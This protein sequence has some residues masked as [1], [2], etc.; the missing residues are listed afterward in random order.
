MN[1]NWH[2]RPSLSIERLM[3]W[4]CTIGL[5]FVAGMYVGEEQGAVKLQPCPL[6]GKAE[7]IRS[8]VVGGQ[9]TCTYATIER[10]GRKFKWEI[11]KV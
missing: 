8:S 3:I 11:R 7:L 6:A 9:Q 4:V 2:P 5:S 10:N 1:R